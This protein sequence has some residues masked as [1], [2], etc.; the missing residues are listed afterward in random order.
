[1]RKDNE[2]LPAAIA[3]LEAEQAERWEER[4]A[5]GWKRAIGMSK[6]QREQRRLEKLADLARQTV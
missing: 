5:E 6:E 1:M 3:A 2:L 4:T